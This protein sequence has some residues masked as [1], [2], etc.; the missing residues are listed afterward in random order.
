MMK[1]IEGG[2][3]QKMEMLNLMIRLKI[4]S[5]RT[6]VMMELS[7]NRLK[8]QKNQRITMICLMTK[9]QEKRKMRKKKKRNLTQAIK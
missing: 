8:I 4:S 5:M 6:L 1:K 7:M 9:A 2:Q 3:T